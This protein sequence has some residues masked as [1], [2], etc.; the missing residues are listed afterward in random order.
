M[1]PPKKGEERTET[2]GEKEKG[3]TPPGGWAK[4]KK[5]QAL[6]YWGNQW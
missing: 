4:G 6:L 2:A 3:E 5:K 1:M